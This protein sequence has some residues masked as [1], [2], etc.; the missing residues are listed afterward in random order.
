MPRDRYDDEDDDR[1]RRRRR[2]DDDMDDEERPHRSRRRD[3]DDEDEDR[4]RRSRRRRDED[5]R[6]ATTQGNGMAVASLVLG[7]VSICFGPITGIIGGILGLM[8][9]SKPSGKGMAVT[10]MILSGAFSLLWIGG[11]V[12]LYMK[13]QEL[14]GRSASANNLKAVG[15]A[16]HN[17][18][19]VHGEFPSPYVRRPGEM[20]GQPVADLDRRLGWRVS[21]VPYLPQGG[22]SVQFKQDEPW[23]SPSNLPLSNTVVKDYVDADARTDPTTR[24]RCFYDNGAVFET[25]GRGIRFTDVTDGTSN[26]IFCVDGGEKVTWTRFQ[27]YKFDPQGQLPPL[28]RP[29]KDGYNVVLCDG[30]VRWVKKS[31]DPAVVKAMITRHG[32]EVVTLP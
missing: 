20:P 12:L 21:L 4:P 28:G 23:D 18:D 25:R 32:G 30:S 11:A 22:P 9:M 10:G 16:S 17:Y 19:S 26:T 3:E 8:G 2:D 27:E 6:P 5:A 31:V 24:I 15:L 7:I 29:D 1:P 13:G 14:G